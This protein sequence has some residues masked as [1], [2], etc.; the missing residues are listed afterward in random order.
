MNRPGRSFERR[1]EYILAPPPAAT[2]SP[3]VLHSRGLACGT[4]GSVCGEQ[5]ALS[6][7]EG[8]PASSKSGRR[9]LQSLAGRK[10]TKFAKERG[11]SSRCGLTLQPRR[12]WRVDRNVDVLG[13]GRVVVFLLASTGLADAADDTRGREEQQRGGHQGNDAQSHKNPH[14]LCSVPHH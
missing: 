12:A 2:N 13:G 6:G 3:A 1:S 7:A 11:A 10:E 5:T 4:W 14:H 9:H 8:G